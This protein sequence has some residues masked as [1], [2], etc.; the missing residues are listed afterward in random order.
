MS[1]LD[2]YVDSIVSNELDNGLTKHI[3]KIND[4]VYF[5]YNSFNLCVGP[6]GSSKTTSV[7]KELMKLTN[8]ISR[9]LKP[10]FYQL[11]LYVPVLIFPKQLLMA[12][13]K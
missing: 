7:L 8:L 4:N 3:S 5:K 6:Q 13:S 9:H 1:V 2:E 10:Q 11:A 12:Q